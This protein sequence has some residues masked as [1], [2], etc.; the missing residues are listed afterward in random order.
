ML[1]VERKRSVLVTG[2]SSGIGAAVCQALLTKGH[3]VVGLS[4][5]Q[6]CFEGAFTHEEADLASLEALPQRLE[7]II[8]THDLDSAVLAAGRGEFR[9]L[10]EFSYEQI[11]ALINLDLTAQIYCARALVPS[12]KTRGGGDLVFIGS[13]AALR[14]G[15]KGAIYSA[16]KFGL[17]GFAQA[18]REEGAAAGLRVCLINPGMV[19]TPFFEPLTFAPG[20]GESE[21]LVA[22]DVA[23][24]VMLA[25]DAREGAVFDQINLSPQKKVIR[26]QRKRG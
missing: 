18:L 17:R 2:A 24:A 6:V 11:Q 12:L 3:R 10:E 26:F 5:R 25:L 23:A 8:N 21:H 4:R 20:Q 1:D 14:G 22:E 16:A 15:K 9:S 13:E 19:E 7:S